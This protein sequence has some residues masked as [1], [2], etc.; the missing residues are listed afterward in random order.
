VQQARPEEVNAL[1][2]GW[3]G[4]Q[5][6]PGVGAGRGGIQLIVGRDTA[7]RTELGV[8]DAT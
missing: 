2:T 1:L 3:L 6:L 5:W 7:W 8:H 4:W